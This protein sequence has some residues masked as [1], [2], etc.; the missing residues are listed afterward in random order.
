LF[1][2][3]KKGTLY[4]TPLPPFRCGQSRA[5]SLREMAARYDNNPLIWATTVFWGN[6]WVRLVRTAP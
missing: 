6:P 4:V 5:T 3:G 2:K 1:S